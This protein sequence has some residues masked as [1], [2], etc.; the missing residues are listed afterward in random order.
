MRRGRG[1][2]KWRKWRK[3]EG[4][5]RGEVMEEQKRKRVRVCKEKKKEEGWPIRSDGIYVQTQG[6]GGKRRA[7]RSWTLS[8]PHHPPVRFWASMHYDDGFPVAV[9]YHT[10]LIPGPLPMVAAVLCSL[11]VCVP[12]FRSFRFNLW[13]SE[14][15]LPALSTLNSLLRFSSSV[16]LVLVHTL[17]R[18][19]HTHVCV[20]S[21]PHSPTPLPFWL[22]SCN[23]DKGWR[24]FVRTRIRETIRPMSDQTWTIVSQMGNECTMRFLWTCVHVCHNMILGQMV[25]RMSKGEKEAL[26]GCQL[27]SS[28]ML[29][30]AS[31]QRKKK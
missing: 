21:F 7:G 4:R 15:A 9:D 17:T 11:C 19:I 20:L 5:K 23:W 16:V 1:R 10:I 28:P 6:V 22:K 26:H 25:C 24:T 3:W 14:C 13:V 18:H 27:I 31:A 30:G 12:I 2:R 8:V 29:K